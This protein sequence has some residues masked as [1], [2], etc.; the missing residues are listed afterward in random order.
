VVEYLCDEIAVIYLGRI[1][2]QGRPE[3]LFNRCA[4]PYTRAL[5]EAVPRTRPGR[6]R[7]RRGAQVIA[8]QSGGSRGCAYAGRCPFADAH[9]RAVAPT[10]RS[11]G[12]GHSAACHHAETVMALAPLADEP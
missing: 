2:E 11:V 5:L 7:R 6:D 4:H 9:C 12:P 3:D 10:A 8:S 1:V